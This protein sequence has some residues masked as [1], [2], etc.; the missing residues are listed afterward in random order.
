MFL[1]KIVCG[2][3]NENVYSYDIA[4][5]SPVQDGSVS[6]DGTSSES[7]HSSI[8]SQ[9]NM[10]E[11]ICYDTINSH[12]KEDLVVGSHS[13]PYAPYPQIIRTEQQIPYPDYNS[14]SEDEHLR[15][16]TKSKEMQTKLINK[17]NLQ[18]NQ[19]RELHRELAYRQKTGDLL[20]K[21][22]N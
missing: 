14:S 20:P 11:Q 2:H 17:N 6:S 12:S 21:N 9:T 15:K 4:S 3:C 16:S 22:R 10:Y 5:S 7:G 18:T 19:K 8:C 13:V 1:K